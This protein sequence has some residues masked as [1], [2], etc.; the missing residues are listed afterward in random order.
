MPLYANHAPIVALP[1]H[2]FDHTV[3]GVG[4]CRQSGR[5]SSDRLMVKRIHGELLGTQ[6]RGET[7]VGRDVHVVYAFVARPVSVMRQR[8]GP[9]AGD[10]LHEGSAQRHVDDLD[11]AAD[12]ERGQASRLRGEDQ[13][14]LQC[15]AFTMDVTNS[16]MR[17]RL[18]PLW[19]DVLAS[20]EQ[21]TVHAIEQGVGPRRVDDGKHVRAKSDRDHGVGV[22]RIGANAQHAANDFRGGGD[23]DGREQT[24][25]WVEVALDR[26]VPVS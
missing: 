16:V 24:P 5:K 14:Q 15:V 23:S 8:A 18:V 10:V 17:D 11:T 20:G 19:L 4:N 21:Q 6:C 13:G 1:L 3:W 25:L 7:R 22:R 26:T 12:S 9:L 2:S